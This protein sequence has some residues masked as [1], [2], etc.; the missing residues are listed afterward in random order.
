MIDGAQVWFDGVFGDSGALTTDP[1]ARR[2]VGWHGHSIASLCATPRSKLTLVTGR[3]RHGRYPGL[4]PARAIS[5]RR[6]TAL[7]QSAGRL[8]AR[9]DQHLRFRRADGLLRDDRL[10]YRQGH[11]R[12]HRRRLAAQR[13][14]HHHRRRLLSI[15]TSVFYEI[16]PIIS[17][18]NVGGSWD[19]T[20]AYQSRCSVGLTLDPA[21]VIALA[22]FG[23]PSRR[24]FPSTGR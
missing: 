3:E 2:D 13:H 15:S 8:A 22:Q 12:R 21:A 11:D 24:R 7:P 1:L 18:S 16:G 23:L 20:A 14:R 5:R 9:H 17:S 6:R 19:G 10:A 4:L